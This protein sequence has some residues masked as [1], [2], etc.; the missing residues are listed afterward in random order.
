MLFII[1]AYYA[2]TAESEQNKQRAAALSRVFHF[3]KMTTLERVRAC[4]ANA[5]YEDDREK[6]DANTEFTAR[7]SHRRGSCCCYCIHPPRRGTCVFRWPNGH[8]IRIHRDDLG[9]R[10]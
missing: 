8:S 10:R 2:W 7:I 9:K 4:D 6:H 5:R 1:G 3:D